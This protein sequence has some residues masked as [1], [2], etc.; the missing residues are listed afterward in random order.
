MKLKLS[1][2]EYMIDRHLLPKFEPNPK[3]SWKNVAAAGVRVRFPSHPMKRHEDECSFRKHKFV[4]WTSE[5]LSL[6]WSS[7][8]LLLDSSVA[9]EGVGVSE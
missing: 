6:T 4:V 8:R 2:I 7:P 3:L 9:V 5:G 1:G